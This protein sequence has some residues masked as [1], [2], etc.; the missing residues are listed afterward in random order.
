[1]SGN[2]PKSLESQQVTQPTSE[3]SNELNR[4][5]LTRDT[6]MSPTPKRKR[7]L[8]VHETATQKFLELEENK[9]KLLCEEKEKG[10]KKSEDYHFFM[11]LIPH[12]TQLILSSNCK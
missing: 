4:A 6:Q 3:P 5:N 8:T 12:M 1:M 7:L 11:S 10:I 9:M 2:L